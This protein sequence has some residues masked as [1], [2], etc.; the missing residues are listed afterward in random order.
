M[1]RMGMQIGAHS[2]SHPNLADLG[3]RDIEVELRRSREV[4]EDG[5]GERVELMAYPFGV[6]QRH[7]TRVAVRLAASTGYTLA[8]AMTSKGVGRRD[9]FAVPRFCIVQDTV[10]TLRQKVLGAW[11]VIG[12]WQE[13]VPLALA[14]HVE[15]WL[16]IDYAAAARQVSHSHLLSR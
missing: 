7:L 6:P 16:G 10:E 14:R 2:Y 1:R 5:L 11:D 4:L 8:A 9:C 12:L 15:R 3:A 13:R